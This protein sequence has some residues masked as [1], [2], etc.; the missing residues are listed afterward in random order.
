MRKKNYQNFENCFQ[1]KKN[2]Y[3]K[4]SIYIRNKRLMKLINIMKNSILHIIFEKNE[5]FIKF[6]LKI[7][8]NYSSSNSQE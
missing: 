4:Q 7:N 6:L 5:N 2:N 8:Y 1:N 3:F